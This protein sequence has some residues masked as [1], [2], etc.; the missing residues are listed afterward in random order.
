MSTGGTGTVTDQLLPLV[1]IK[2]P[3]GIVETD[4]RTYMG[5]LATA[6][7]AMNEPL[8]GMKFNPIEYGFAF[9]KDFPNDKFI[10]L[11]RYPSLPYWNRHYSHPYM[12][13]LSNFTY[14]KDGSTHIFGFYD[15]IRLH[16]VV[17]DIANK[18]LGYKM[19]NNVVA[20]TY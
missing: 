1:E 15:N 17:E 12:E 14:K 4:H 2:I 9:T 6:L 5:N 8:K 3:R 20:Y 7:I 10:N 16:M 19:C 13:E 18:D 11:E